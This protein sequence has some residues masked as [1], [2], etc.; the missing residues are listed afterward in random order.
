MP[1]GAGGRTAHGDL[2]GVILAVG[3][4]AVQIGDIVVRRP[5][6]VDRDGGCVGVDAADGDVVFIGVLGHIL[7]HIGRELPGD[8]ADGVAV[9]IRIRDGFVADN[10]AGTGQVVNGDGLAEL[11]LKGCAEGTQAVV[12]AAAGAPG[13]DRVD[14]LGGI[15][16]RKCGRSHHGHGQHQNQCDSN[17]FLAG[18]HVC[19]P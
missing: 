7:G 18:F 11:L 10:A 3:D 14:A 15:V 9:G 6:G 12:R 17:D 16:R 5:L 2:T 4:K 1:H 19:P 8:H 13:V